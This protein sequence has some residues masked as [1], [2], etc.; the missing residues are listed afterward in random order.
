MKDFYLYLPSNTRYKGNTPAQFI[1]LLAQPYELVGEW[2]VGLMEIQYQRTWYNVP[3][4]Q[5]VHIGSKTIPIPEGMYN[6]MDDLLKILN[7]KIK[8]GLGGSSDI[9]VDINSIEAKQKTRLKI[10]RTDEDATDQDLYFSKRLSD[11]LGF[12][13]T[14]PFLSGDRKSEHPADIE[15]GM[16]NLYVYCDLIEPVAVGDARVPLLR[17]VPIQKGPIVTTSYSKV[18]YYPLMRKIFG[19]VEINIKGD[20]GEM[21]PFVGGKSYVTLHFRQKK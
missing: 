13:K 1:V 20:T 9:T 21:I 15:D 11:M 5:F 18:F 16:H 6:T 7:K 19:A 17:I 3:P 10:S 12:E 14:G 8:W 4:E 2:E